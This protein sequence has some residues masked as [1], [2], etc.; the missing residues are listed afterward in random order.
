MLGEALLFESSIASLPKPTARTVEAF[1][2]E[3]HQGDVT[4]VD[5]YALLGG[6]SAS[7]F[8]DKDDLIALRSVPHEDRLT[9]FVQ[10]HLGILFKVCQSP[11][12]ISIPSRSF[13]RACRE[14]PSATA[15]SG[16]PIGA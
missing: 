9:V 4:S 3:F 15:T 11:L 7:I 16:Y 2:Y 12:L 8:N 10:D 14:R 6:H 5:R 1:R 13:N